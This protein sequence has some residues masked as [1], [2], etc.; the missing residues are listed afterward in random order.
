VLFA[1]VVDTLGDLRRTW[2]LFPV[3]ANVQARGN[4]G[5]VNASFTLEQ[6]K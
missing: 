5:V 6:S 3:R 4:V 1:S 2:Q